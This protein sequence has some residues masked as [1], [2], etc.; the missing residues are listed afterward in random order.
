MHDDLDNVGREPMHR[1]HRGC[2]VASA[3]LYQ[4]GAG[5]R[6]GLLRG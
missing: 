6:R 1:M 2:Q 4:F 5:N 3:L